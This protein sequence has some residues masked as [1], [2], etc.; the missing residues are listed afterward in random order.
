MSD[1]LSPK[2]QFE[3]IHAAHSIEHVVFVLRFE[4][5]LDDEIFAQVRN[6]AKK[7]E[8]EALS[9]LRNGDRSFRSRESVLLGG[10]R[11]SLIGLITP[12][13][14]SG[15]TW[16]ATVNEL[17]WTLRNVY[18]TATLVHNNSTDGT[19]A[20]QYHIDDYFDLV[21]GGRGF[22]YDMG[23]KIAGCIYHGLLDNSG[24][25]VTVD[26]QRKY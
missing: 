2:G 24:P 17:T 14:S 25:H 5:S 11:G 18:I 23:A 6:A 13:P 3:P 9:H 4:S 12:L 26:W 15:Q 7:F 16:S 20:V 8:T 10:D 1:G 19:F 21:P 22:A